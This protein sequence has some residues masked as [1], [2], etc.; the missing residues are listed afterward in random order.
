MILG[1]LIGA[2]RCTDVKSGTYNLSS[3]ISTTILFPNIVLKEIQN[4]IYH[5]RVKN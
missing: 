5:V 1:R 3:I 2:K 4:D